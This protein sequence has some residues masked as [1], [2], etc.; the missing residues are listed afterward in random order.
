MNLSTPSPFILNPSPYRSDANTYKVWGLTVRII[1][2]TY[3]ESKSMPYVVVL[4]VM[5]STTKSIAWNHH[6]MDKTIAICVDVANKRYTVMN[7][8]LTLRA[9]RI[10]TSSPP[11]LPITIRNVVGH[12][13]DRISRRY[14]WMVGKLGGGDY[15]PDKHVPYAHATQA[16]L[17]A[18]GRWNHELSTINVLGSHFVFLIITKSPSSTSHCFKYIHC[19]VGNNERSNAKQLLH[20]YSESLANM[21]RLSSSPTTMFLFLRLPRRIHNHLILLFLR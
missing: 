6:Q 21:W 3:S 19:I 12:I 1:N 15:P 10:H 11:H 4:V 5:S 2:T 16:L 8:S 13:D 9:I 20:E 18:V 7:C 14:G 17:M